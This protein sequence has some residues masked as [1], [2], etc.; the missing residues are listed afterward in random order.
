M[1]ALVEVPAVTFDQAIAAPCAPRERE[2]RIGDERQEHEQR[3]PRRPRAGSDARRAERRGEESQRYGADIAQEH[4]RARAV[5]GEERN[6]RRGKCQA[7][8]RR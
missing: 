1:Q 3:K 8:R 7:R 5:D 2:R 6:D 4:R